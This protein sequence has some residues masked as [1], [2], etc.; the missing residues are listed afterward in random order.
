VLANAVAGDEVRFQ[1]GTYVGEHTPTNSGSCNGAL[2][3]FTADPVAAPG[4][5]IFQNGYSSAHATGNA[6][7][8]ILVGKRGIQIG[9]G[10]TFSGDAWPPQVGG[11]AGSCPPYHSY[12]CNVVTG[13]TFTPGNTSFVPTGEHNNNMIVGRI[14]DDS[15]ITDNVFSNTGSVYDII[16]ASSG[17]IIS[18]NTITITT[19]CPNNDCAAGIEINGA[20]YDSTWVVNNRLI[21]SGTGTGPIDA[22]GLWCDVFTAGI[23][24]LNNYVEGVWSN[25]MKDEYTC[26]QNTWRY[27]IFFGT[28]RAQNGIGNAPATQDEWTA[29]E[30]FDHNTIVN[31]TEHW[32]QSAWTTDIQLTNNIFSSLSN[33]YLAIHTATYDPANQRTQAG[34]LFDYNLYCPATGCGAGTSLVHLYS[35]SLTPGPPT[36]TLAEWQGVTGQEANS[37]VGAAQFT[38]TATEDFSLQ[39]GSPALGTGSGGTN[40]GACPGNS[41]QSPN[42]S[43]DH[44]LCGTYS[45]VPSITVAASAATIRRGQASTVTWASATGRSCTNTMNRSTGSYGAAIVLP[46]AL[47]NYTVDCENTQGSAQGSTAVA[48]TPRLTTPTPIAWWKMNEASGTPLDV[49]SSRACTPTGAPTFVAGQAGMGNALNLN[50]TTQWCDVANAAPLNPAN[51]LTIAVWV[52][53]DTLGGVLVTKANNSTATSTDDQYILT[54]AGDQVRFTINGGFGGWQS[55]VVRSRTRLVTGTWYHVAGV[56]DGAYIMVYINGVLEHI[57]PFAETMADNGMGVRLGTNSTGTIHLDGQ[58][59]DV[60]IYN[61]AL[62]AADVLA[63]MTSTAQS[64]PPATMTITSPT[65][66]D[67]YQASNATLALGGDGT[68]GTTVSWECATCNPT[69]GSGTGTTSWTASVT[70]ALGDNPV[71][72][73][74]AD[75]GGQIKTDQITITYTPASTATAPFRLVR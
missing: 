38:N 64:L 31:G 40:K 43:G 32:Y 73:Q 41:L 21:E 51:Q 69:T 54:V 24:F 72:V 4:S 30:I 62:Y 3:T 47:T 15:V 8:W 27:N 65:S 60:R 59:D 6:G 63:I 57:V 2:I 55:R 23:H 67:T 25:A 44:F 39:G 9:P 46:T 53:M 56:Y 28:S 36:E 18:G 13:N 71:T 14:G 42:H 11:C 20:A 26:N 52:R 10:L 35:G 33:G 17:Y 45:A 50:G 75:A 5:V 22:I 19:P 58:L 61:T 7:T 34:A 68:A 49:I 29:E 66:N 12:G 74:A 37:V 1:A 48:V 70:L 16:S